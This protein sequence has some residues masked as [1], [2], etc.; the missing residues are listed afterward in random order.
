MKDQQFQK[1]PFPTVDRFDKNILNYGTFDYQSRF[2]GDGIS[3]R[4]SDD[5]VNALV[6]LHV[7]NT[8]NDDQSTITRM[9]FNFYEI[10]KI[11]HELRCSFEEAKTLGDINDAELRHEA[12]ERF[13]LRRGGASTLKRRRCSCVMCCDDQSNHKLYPPTRFPTFTLFIYKY[14]PIY[15]RDHRQYLNNSEYYLQQGVYCVLHSTT[16]S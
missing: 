16:Y 14:L 10:E 13:Y 5:D 8:Q 9:F 1:Y 7:Y 2:L 4:L 15:Y 6:L 12:S 3:V 11:K